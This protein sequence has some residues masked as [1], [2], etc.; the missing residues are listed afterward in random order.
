MS[1]HSSSQHASEVAALDT[2]KFR[3][4]KEATSLETE[5]ERLSS[6]LFDLRARVAELDAQGPEGG[7]AIKKDETN[8]ALVLKSRVFGLFGTAERGDGGEW[9][10]LVLGNAKKGESKVVQVDPKGDKKVWADMIWEM[11]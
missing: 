7:D 10:K 5:T 1:S 11:V 8:D 4:A 3:I 6:Q 2:Q 9:N